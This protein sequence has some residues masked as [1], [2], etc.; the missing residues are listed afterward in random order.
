MPRISDKIF[1]EL[2]EIVYRESGI[3]L[4]DKRELLDARL[5]S[6]TRKKGYGRPEEVLAR[7][8]ADQTGETLIEFLDQ[9]STNLT[10]FFRE[11]AHFDFLAKVF[12]P[13]LTTRKKARRQN[14]IRFWSAAC[15]SGEEPYS[16]AIT[17]F[18]HLGDPSAWDIKILA[19]DIST[20]MLRKGLTG[21]YSRQ[22][23]MKA[24]PSTVQRYFDRDG[25][26]NN[27]VYRVKDEIKRLVV[28][29]RLNLLR[30]S[31]PFQG[32]FD[33]IVCRNVMIYF[34]QPTK[35][36]LLQRFHRYLAEGGC[37]FTGHAESLTAYEHLF[38]RVQVA[39]YRK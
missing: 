22:E 11:P 20:R 21:Q 17:A 32:R 2:A 35:Q 29:R 7:L 31:Y 16:L 28:F 30:E 10:Y 8:K 18:D 14:K 15:S 4:A 1:K 13:E 34:D 38:K 5:A 24:P 33:L 6:L 39:V 26:R 9:V 23:V 37:L 3:V 36:S 19:T 25:N 27:V 12:L